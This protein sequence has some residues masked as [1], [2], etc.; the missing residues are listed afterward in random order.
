MNTYEWI[1]LVVIGIGAFLY[2]GLWVYTEI[3]RIIKIHRR[4]RMK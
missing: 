2:G 1:A 4:D 3:E